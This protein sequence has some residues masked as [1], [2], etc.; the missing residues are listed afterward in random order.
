ANDTHA[1]PVSVSVQSSPGHGSAV[2]AG[3][4]ITYTPSANYHGLDGFLYSVTDTAGH[5]ATG[6]VIVTVTSVN[7]APTAA[8]TAGSIAEDG[9]FDGSVS[10]VDV[11]S[12]AL[13]YSKVEDAAHGS[14]TVNANGTF[15]Y[16]PGPDYNGSDSFT[17][18]A[19]DGKADSNTATV[20]ITVTAVNDAPVATPD[21][22]STDE[23]V[24]LNGQLAG[25]D[26]ETDAAA[27]TFA[28]ASEPTHG[29]VIVN[30]DG[31]FTYDPADNYNGPDSFTFTANDGTTDS[32]AATFSITVNSVN[33]AP[34]I[35]DVGAQVIV[36]GHSLSGLEFTVEDVD[37]DTISISGTSD[38]HSLVLD[39][40]IGG[41]VVGDTATVTVTPLLGQD[42]TAEITVIVSDGTATAS[43]TFTL[44]VQP[45][46]QPV[47]NDDLLIVAD[48]LSVDIDVLG[49]DT[50]T[51]NGPLTVTIESG[52]DPVTEGAVI[53]G[54]DGT[55]HLDSVLGAL[56][57]TFDYRVTDADG[58]FD[59]GT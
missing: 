32:A 13:T 57:V 8:A 24:N 40:G 55:I 56:S 36:E 19:N 9:H 45:D 29:S 20:T 11:E 39:A 28:K 51:G 34:T 15:T 35:S 42:G 5:S 53:I 2:V 44:T 18:K 25:T 27:L 47:A 12:D 49:N 33:D 6:S 23:D 7:D 38:N 58:D 22:D 4:K 43:D 48:L 21:S 10:A 16:T 30:A 50:G 17:F 54:E 26:V 1:L 14:V 59:T 46:E 41:T 31:S 37:G 52:L 3:G